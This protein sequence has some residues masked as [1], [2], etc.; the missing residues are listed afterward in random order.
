M[1]VVTKP[2]KLAK[3]QRR[4]G[5]LDKKLLESYREMAND[6]AREREADAWSEGLLQDIFNENISYE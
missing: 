1:C 2:N 4:S 6:D 3:R 5:Q